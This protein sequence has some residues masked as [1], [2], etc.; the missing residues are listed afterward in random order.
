MSCQQLYIEQMIQILNTA[1]HMHV[2]FNYDMSLLKGGGVTQK[3][4]V[5]GGG[6]G[7]RKNED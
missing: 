6:G 3:M 1:K 7:T 4:T 2:R 5:N